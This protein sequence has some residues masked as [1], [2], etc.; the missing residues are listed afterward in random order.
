M[1]KISDTNKELFKLFPNK[2][3]TGSRIDAA[4]RLRKRQWHNGWECTGLDGDFAVFTK[5]T[6]IEKGSFQHHSR[7]INILDAL[8]CISG[9]QESLV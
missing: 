6:N 9:K 2:T 4:E 5:Y 8:D 1:A 3:L 7:H